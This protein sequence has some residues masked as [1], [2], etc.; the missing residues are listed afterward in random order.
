MD[1]EGLG[2]KL[3]E[4][5]VS[6]GLVTGYGDLYRL[7]DEQ[8]L[9]LERMG[10][11]SSEKLLAGIE[12]SKTRGLARLLNA[13]SIRHVG[14]SVARVLAESFGSMDGLRAASIDQ[15]SD[16]NE[17]GPIIAESA[18]SF[19]ASEFGTATIDDLACLGVVME[20]PQAGGDAEGSSVLEGKTLVVTG[21]LV[22][23]KRDEIKEL[24]LQHG[25]RAASSVSSKTDYLVAGEKAGSKLAKAQSLGVTVLTEDEF[26]ALLES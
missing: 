24:I 12:A 4:Q 3:V 25:G 5:L 19:L 15:L 17:I 14:N 26:E 18:H 20:A 16:I 8:L 21:T 7:T 1:I 22:K 23:Y 2:D 10:K 9:T 13:L 11:R 6:E